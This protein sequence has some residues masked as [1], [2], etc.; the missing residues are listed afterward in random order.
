MV[1]YLRKSFSKKETKVIKIKN[2]FYKTVICEGETARE[3]VESAVRDGLSLESADLSGV[4]LSGLDLSGV[5]LRNANFYGADL[6]G[7]DVRG[8]L[9]RGANLKWANIQDLKFNPGDIYWSS[10]MVGGASYPTMAQYY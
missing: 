1:V 8:A 3:A 6:T 5:D 9:M 7:A 2:A 4:D 10:F